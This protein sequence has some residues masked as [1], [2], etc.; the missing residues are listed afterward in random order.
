MLTK[1]RNTPESII[2]F[3]LIGATVVPI[4]IMLCPLAWCPESLR[5]L[6]LAA[7]D[8]DKANK[9]QKALSLITFSE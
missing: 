2:T 7:M 4:V 8:E 6:M 3:W 9:G 5:I 1:T